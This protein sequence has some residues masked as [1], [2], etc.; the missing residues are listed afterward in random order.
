MPFRFRGLD[1]PEVVLIDPKVFP[2]ERGFFLET[3]KHSEFSSNGIQERFVQENHSH[4]LRRTLRGLHYQKNPKAQSK[5]VRV[6]A[7]TIFDVVVDIRKGS[8]RYG[9][10][11]G[12]NLSAEN[13]QM[14]YVPAGFAHGACVMSEEAALLYMVSSEYAPEC[15]R[16]VIW[17]DPALG[18]QWPQDKPI[19]S[20]R[21]QMWPPLA[22]A[23]NNFVYGDPNARSI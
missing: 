1:L 9:R 23:D 10:W 22:Y 3:Y 15:E 13:K 20:S 18:I 7:G 8:P 6:V 21:D 5:I 4:S 17:N 16:G 19:L 11:I 12:V 14:L 2:D